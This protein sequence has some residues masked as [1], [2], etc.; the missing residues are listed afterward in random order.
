[1]LHTIENIHMAKYGRAVNKLF[2]QLEKL[3]FFLLS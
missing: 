2:C 1:M 3:I